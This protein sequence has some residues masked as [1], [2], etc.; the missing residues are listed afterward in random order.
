MDAKIVAKLLRECADSIEN[1]KGISEGFLC[2]TKEK[3]NILIFTG[4]PEF[5]WSIRSYL[6]SFSLLQRL[7]EKR[8]KENV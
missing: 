2:E 8:D 7:Q 3:V 1:G 5:A 6:K 4:E